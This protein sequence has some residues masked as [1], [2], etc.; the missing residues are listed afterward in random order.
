MLHGIVSNDLSIVRCLIDSGAD[1][2]AKDQVHSH[3]RF[4]FFLDFILLPARRH[5]PVSV[6]LFVSVC[7][8][9]VFY[10]KE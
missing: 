9:F 8:K 4:R 2:N 7:H 10:Q 6:C 5:G 1:V 3:L